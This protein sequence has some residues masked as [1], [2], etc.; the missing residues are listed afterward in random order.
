MI[1]IVES[2]TPTLSAVPAPPAKPS[3]ATEVAIWV[4][5]IPASATLTPPDPK[6]RVEPSSSTV[7]EAGDDPLKVKSAIPSPSVKD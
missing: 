6:D 2:S 1:S 5:V 3:P 7:T 4:A